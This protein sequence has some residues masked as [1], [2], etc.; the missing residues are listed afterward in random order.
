MAVTM[1]VVKNCKIKKKKKDLR[2]K[3]TPLRDYIC[4]I[5]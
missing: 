2:G 4:N 3:F 1:N 5:C